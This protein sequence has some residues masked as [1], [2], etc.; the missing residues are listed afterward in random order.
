MS[1]LGRHMPS[2]LRRSLYQPMQSFVPFSTSGMQRS[3]QVDCYISTINDA[4]TNLAIEEWLLRET[5]PERYILYLW[6]NKSCVVVGRN[7][8]PFQ[9]CN[10]RFMRSHGIPLVRR[11]SGGGAVYHDMGNSIYTIFMPRQ[12]FS[13]RA[14]A[15]LVSRAL[16]NLDIPASVNDRHD[17]VVD[18]YKVSG[19]AYKITSSRAY[20]HGTMLI[21]TDTDILKG[22]LSK[23][24][25]TNTGI[26]SKGVASVPSPVTNLR[27]YSY[28]VDHQ[29]FCES[30]LAEFVQDYND[31][32]PVEP[33]IFDES[34]IRQL[35]EMV[36]VTKKELE[37]WDWIYG[38]T[39]EFTNTTDHEFDWG[40]VRAFIRARHGIITEADLSTTSLGAHEVT[41]VSAI[42]VALRGC[43]YSDQAVNDAVRKINE[44]IPG[45]INPENEAI[46]RELAT[47]LQNKF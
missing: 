6:R 13:R 45:L 42:S 27:Q 12:A 35:P 36:Q 14:N 16:Q 28:T 43:H 7:Q 1:S 33:I 40:H 21:D 38:Q 44:E 9:E 25:M 10:L 11:R 20:H 29:Q 18:G 34:R 4:Y 19:S 41:V 32:M 2:L 46:A 17:I 3:S 22:C 24:N 39:P 15:D 23:K 31:G 37:T 30:V 8:N 26:V 5:D 47:W